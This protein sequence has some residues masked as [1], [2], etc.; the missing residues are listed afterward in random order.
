MLIYFNQ[1]T[2]TYSSFDDWNIPNPWEQSDFV[3]GEP[4]QKRIRT[5]TTTEEKTLQATHLPYSHSTK[6][7]RKNQTIFLIFKLTFFPLENAE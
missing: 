1:S 7:T 3:S 4:A 6:K 2:S 5:S